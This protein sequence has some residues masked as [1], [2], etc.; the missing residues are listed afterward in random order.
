MSD[1]VK[2]S[3]FAVL[4][5]FFNKDTR[6]LDL[7]AGTGN[8]SFEALSR[9]AR[10]AYAVEQHPQA[11]AIIHKNRDYLK[12]QSRLIC[13]KQDVF[14]FIQKSRGFE[15]F[16]ITLADPSFE[17]KAGKRL[18]ES[19]ARSHLYI[20]G[21]LFVVDTGPK[22]ELPSDCLCFQLFSLRDFRDK[23]VWFYEAK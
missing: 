3:L 14:S 2:E 16:H 18:L 13:R 7:F 1:R 5:P 12:N 19:F 21:S 20:K 10:V 11:L 22:E 6:I 23:K 4:E 8:L 17:L 15:P 9:G